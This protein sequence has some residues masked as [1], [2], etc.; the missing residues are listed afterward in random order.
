MNL[1]GPGELFALASALCWAV[2]VMLYTRSGE[3]MSPFTL[4]LTKNS[5]S[6][7]LL[8]PTAMLFAGSGMPALSTQ[9]WL[10]CV[11]SGVIGIAVADTLYF[12]CLNRIG[13]GR[14]GIVAAL[15]SPSV[16]ALSALF[17]GERLAPLQGVGFCTVLAGV[18][19]VAFSRVARRDVDADQL[20]SGIALGATAVFLMAVGI[21][22]VKRIVE[23]HSLLWIVEIRIL[24]GVAGMLAV[25][26]AQRRSGAL[27]RE[28]RQP[29]RWGQVLLGSFLGTYLAMIFWLAGYKYTLASIASVLNETSSV[30]ILILAWLFLKEPLDRYKIAGVLLTFG[31]VVMMLVAQPE[32]SL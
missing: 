15:F 7:V 11:L 23:Q 13:A 10:V 18:I 14:T 31:G 1:V 25:V 16:V 3:Q 27:I 29:H 5:I 4:N 21:V 32:S 6:A 24:A 28:L 12:A 22:M 8:W 20:R 9:E 17:L 19:V 30:F 2:A 26:L